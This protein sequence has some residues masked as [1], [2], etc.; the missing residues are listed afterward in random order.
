MADDP[1]LTVIAYDISSDRARR[2]VAE[3]LEEIGLRVQESVFEARLSRTQSDGLARRLRKHVG[4]GD[5]IR[6]YPI[7]ASRRERLL[8]LGTGVAAEDGPFLL[9]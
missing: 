4:E 3:I 6:F 8:V 2:Y 9:F 1:M 7:A 5:S